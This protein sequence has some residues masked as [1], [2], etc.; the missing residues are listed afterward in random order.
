MGLFR[1]TLAL[2]VVLGHGLYLPVPAAS[3]DVAVQTFY[4]VSGFYMALVLTERY[5][6]L[7]SFFSNRVLR[8]Y[9]AYLVVLALTLGHALLRWGVGRSST[10]PGLLTYETHF[11]PLDLSGKAYLVLTNLLLVGQ[12]LAL[13]LKLSDGGH[14]LAWTTNALA[15]SPHV[16]TF[17]LVPQSWSLSIELGFYLFAPWL[18]A[19]GTRTLLAILGVTIGLRLAL[20]SIGLTFDPWTYRFFPV[21]LGSFVLGMVLYRSLPYRRASKTT[22]RLATAAVLAA[23]LLLSAA[24]GTWWTRI[25]FYGLVA[26]ALPLAF[27]LTR[28]NR[29]DRYLG[30]LSYPVY[31]VH[32]LVISV[33]LYSGWSGLHLALLILAMVAASSV[34]LHEVVQK[35]VDRFRA[36]RVQ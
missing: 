28:H 34:L 5:H 17:L 12:D 32:L 24:P 6:S 14:S 19:R 10:M 11:A 31:L 22:Q 7:W 35:P 8:L 3:P 18:V 25:A 9:P 4:I 16:E 21:E 13:F 36:A 2:C 20:A 30:E 23:T 26:W 15:T 33:A 27:Q 1:L 29:L